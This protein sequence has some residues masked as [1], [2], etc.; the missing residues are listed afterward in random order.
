M[1]SLTLN[2]SGVADIG[3][4]EASVLVCGGAYSNLEALRAL[5]DAARGL[6][7]PASRIIHTGDVV[8]YCADPV[9]TAELLRTS[10][11]HAIQGNVEESLAA[12]LPDCGC[13]FAEGSTCDQLADEWFSFADARVGKDLRQWMAG[14]PMQ[15]SFE[16]AGARVR[17]V[18]GSVTLLNRYMFAS[19]PDTDFEPEFAAAGADM[20]VAGHSGI[21]FTRR[22]GAR[23]WHN[24]GPLGMPANDGT[25]RAW[26]SVLT[27]ED[28]GVRIEQHALDY[29]H[30]RA[31]EKMMQAGICREYAEALETGLWPS[32][33]VLPETERNATGIPLDPGEPV[34]QESSEAIAGSP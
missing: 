32:L 34:F 10:G 21:P 14:L 12:R 2:T 33:D 23:M 29:D 3:R 6:G 1:D 28:G 8:A 16:M 19:Q 7:I 11:A 24:S 18:H 4:F 17:V 25:P 30:A 26:F 20:I 27:P 15:L 9:E 5:F 31:R 13:G 22:V